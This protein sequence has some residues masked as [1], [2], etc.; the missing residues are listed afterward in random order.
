MVTYWK[1]KDNKHIG[2]FRTLVELADCQVKAVE[3]E[4]GC[5][6]IM[7]I[8]QD[9]YTRYKYKVTVDG[10]EIRRFSTRKNLSKAEER[11]EQKKWAA[12]FN[13]DSIKGIEIKRY[14]I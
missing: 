1:I 11:C 9:N 3:K 2:S 7:S 12:V 4:L 10:C 6:V 5:A 13:I 14:A 8:N